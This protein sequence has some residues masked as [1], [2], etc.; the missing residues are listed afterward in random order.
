MRAHSNGAW[1]L[2][3]GRPGRSRR[4]GGLETQP[5]TLSTGKTPGTLSPSL[6]IPPLLPT[7]PRP[8]TNYPLIPERDGPAPGGGGG[9]ASGLGHRC[10][11]G[12]QLPEWGCKFSRFR[13][14]QQ[15]TPHSRE[16]T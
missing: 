8:D 14:L 11:C 5:F 13:L 12:P 7:L 6:S 9:R 15:A 10:P 16:K 3:E 2:Q 4:C 1:A